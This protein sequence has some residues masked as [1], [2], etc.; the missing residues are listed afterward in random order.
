VNKGCCLELMSLVRSINHVSH[1]H[2]ARLVLGEHRSARRHTCDPL[3][4]SKRD[5]SKPAGACGLLDHQPYGR[6][7]LLVDLRRSPALLLRPANPRME[8]TSLRLRQSSRIFDKVRYGTALKQGRI[9]YLSRCR[10]LE[11]GAL[12]ISPVQCGVVPPLTPWPRVQRLPSAGAS[13]LQSRAEC[14][15]RT[16]TAKPHTSIYA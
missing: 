4:G 13:L 11:P 16:L 6:R 14:P 5:S 15:T 2:E 3:D 10:I 8:A 1:E 7:R 9:V 12:R